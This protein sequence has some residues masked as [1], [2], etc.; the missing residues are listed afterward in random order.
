LSA[1]RSNDILSVFYKLTHL[2][3]TSQ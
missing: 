3:W 1:Y 2:Y